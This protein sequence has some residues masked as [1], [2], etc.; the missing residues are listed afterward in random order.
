[1]N[2][3]KKYNLANY[4]NLNEYSDYFYNSR[5]NFISSSSSINSNPIARDT[6]SEELAEMR[7]AIKRLEQNLYLMA[8]E[9]QQ[10]I[11][12]PPT[13]AVT[14][15]GTTQK[16]LEEMLKANF[17]EM[18]QNLQN[19]IRRTFY[20]YNADKTGRP[21]FASES[22][23][24]SIMFTRCTETYT[25]NA[26]WLSVL[27]IQLFK[28][29]NEP[30]VIIQNNVHPGNC[31]AFKGKTADIFIKLA[32]EIYPTSFSIEHIPIELTPTHSLDTAPQNFSVYGYE[33]ENQIDVNEG[34][35]LGSFRDDNTS[36]E[37]LQFFNVQNQVKK[38]L[39]IIELKIESNGGNKDYTCLY[40]FRVHGIML[41]NNEL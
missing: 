4:F 25:K 5:Q 14:T 30:R 23:G 18:S 29:Y 11:A 33:T 40:K 26:Q 32:A 22:I 1:M 10:L 21:D 36:S 41:E 6:C 12:N 27:N 37:V 28:V 19:M 2:N 8:N 35:H 39:S 17:T 3:Y 13:A 31:Y 38:V 20:L 16:Q 15:T 34:I 7:E 24:A 9:K